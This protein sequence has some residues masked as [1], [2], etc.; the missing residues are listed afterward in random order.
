MQNNPLSLAIVGHTN[1]GKT[2]LLRT[3]LRDSAFGEVA[4]APSTTRH[5]ERSVVSDGPDTLV[6]L[7]DTPGLEDAGGLLDWLESHTS[8]RADGIERL[9]RFLDSPEAAADFN[10][11]A[12]VL[13]Q[14]LQS[15]MALYVVDAREPVLNKYKD[16]LTVLS[17]CAKPVMPVFNFTGGQD[18][19]AWTAMLARRNLHVYSAFDTV[20]FDFEGEI[21]LWN[22]LSTMLP[23]RAALDRLTAMRRR[24]W[25]QL[26]DEA[27][28][29]IADFLL[30][31]AAYR[32]ED[33][34]DAGSDGI[35]QTMQAEVRQLERQLQQR[36]LR[37][38]RFYQSGVDTAEWVLKA[39]RQDPFDRDL[40][41]QYGIR[42]GTGAATGALI[43]MG[44][45]MVT[46]GGSLGLGAAIGGII[47]G[48]L[49]NMQDISDKI[50][51]RQTLRIDAET[52]TLL[53]A[54]ALDLL[55]A[56]Q[57]RG[58]AAQ[59]P[60]QLQK[61]NRT[62]WQ[63]SKMPPELNKARQQWKWSSLNTRRPESSRRERAEAAESLW[64]K[65]Q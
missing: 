46:L 62:P 35:L 36:L 33:E 38:Y 51:G 44:V 39:F 7:Y 37:I 56:L 19:S 26:D 65:F 1:T 59:T 12:K 54:R 30:D 18:L 32:Q 60:V 16:E 17:W 57:K 6:Y 5:V 28:R 8:S 14:I 41:V 43:G 63:P 23:A 24:E 31:V 15:D 50:S 45:D 55:D 20:A 61:N 40:L 27:K 52:L 3:L 42:T 49:P 47:G 48:V 2:S 25:R 13:R 64:R 29:E 53:A 11:E 34:A 4:D 10:Q 22:N 58:H 21:R 9:N